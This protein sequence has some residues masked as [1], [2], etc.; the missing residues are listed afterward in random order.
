MV[1]VVVNWSLEILMRAGKVSS[2]VAQ[3]IRNDS[4]SDLCRGSSKLQRFTVR[5]SSE[6][7]SEF[8]WHYFAS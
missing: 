4:R 2:Q 3:N 1:V 5:L 6:S 8:Q 7:K